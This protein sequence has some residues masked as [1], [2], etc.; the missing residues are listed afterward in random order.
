[1]WKSLNNAVYFTPQDGMKIIVRGRVT[2]YPPRGNY[3]FDV[4]T[5]QPAGVGELQLAFDKLKEKL[6]KEGLFDLS[7]KKNIPSFPEKIGIV[8]SIDG[9]ALRDMIS[10]AKRRLPITE[11][12]IA[13][14]KV[15]GAGA[16]E[17]IAEAIKE[18]NQ[19][20][21]IDL[22]IVSRGGGSI[23]D[24]WAFN[25]EV[26]AYAIFNSEIPII[27]G[28]GHEIDFTISDFVADLRAATPTAAMEIALPDQA[29]I[30]SALIAMNENNY[31][32]MKEKLAD[33]FSTINSIEQSRAFKYPENIVNQNSQRLDNVFFK[34]NNSVEK[35]L[36]RCNNKL[37]FIG[38]KL[39]S[40]DIE[41]VLKKGFVLVKQA[42]KFVQRSINFSENN[43]FVLRFYDGNVEIKK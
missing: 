13:P 2:V 19:D 15:Q 12:I 33:I 7:T 1:M 11:L 6:L 4:R 23:E 14:V 29:E 22:I 10:V 41:K 3:Q 40:H 35:L 17:T 21:S 36:N 25:E 39:E 20:E 18:L 27:S 30:F 5:M 26:V 16:A 37:E 34:V 24:L 9:A 38:A 8:T 43:P 31:E 32:L 42:D 28:V